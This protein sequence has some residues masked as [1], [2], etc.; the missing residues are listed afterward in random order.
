LSPFELHVVLWIEP[1]LIGVE[2]IGIVS[3]CA[4][5]ASNAASALFAELPFFPAL[6]AL[7]THFYVSS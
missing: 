6:F 7:F 1:E 3:V 2:E 4:V 5:A